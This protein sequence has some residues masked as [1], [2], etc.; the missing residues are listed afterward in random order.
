MN[1]EEEYAEKGVF[2]K[3]DNFIC[4]KPFLKIKTE[5]NITGRFYPNRAVRCRKTTIIIIIII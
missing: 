4:N 2:N 5:D 3:D 1:C